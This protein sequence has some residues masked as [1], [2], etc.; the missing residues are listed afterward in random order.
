MGKSNIIYKQGYLSASISGFDFLKRHGL[1]KYD[2]SNEPLVMFGCY[3]NMDYNILNS[4]KSEIVIRWCGGDA[5]NVKDVSI[6]QKPNIKHVTP[7]IK[8][9]NL[10]VNKG[11]DCKLKK[12]FLTEEPKALLKGNKVYTY[13]NKNGP[14]RN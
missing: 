3:N 10:L 14:K 7:L 9:K 12:V 1:R 6:F 8:V 4:H 2:N 11:I 13:I 5:L